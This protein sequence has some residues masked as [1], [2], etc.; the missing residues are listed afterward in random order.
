M[1]ERVKELGCLYGI[2]RIAHRYQGSLDA[3]LREVAAIIRDA[4]QYPEIAS[5][6]IVVDGRVCAA[7]GKGPR[8]DVQACP[9][10]VRGKTRGHVQVAYSEER[11]LLDEGPFLKE[12]RNLIEVVAAQVADIIEHEEVER[13]KGLLL[14]QLRHAD[15]LATIGQLAAGM[16]HELNEPLGGI[17]GFAQLARKSPDLPEQAAGDIERIAAAALHAR[18]VIR[19][20]LH[21]AHQTPPSRAEIDLNRL[22]EDALQLLRSHCEHEAIDIQLSFAPTLPRLLGDGGQLRQVFT[23]LMVNALQA[24][25]HGGTITITTT[26]NDAH[27]ILIVEDTGIGIAEDVMDKL[28]LPFFT[29]KDVGVGT[30]LGLPVA[31]GIVAA[32]G[33]SIHVQSKVGQGSRFEIRL[34]LATFP[35]PLEAS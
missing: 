26:A 1:L 5:V 35:S 18:D 24:M 3:I 2:S 7:S 4:W 27:A 6:R 31:H 23:N 22:I 14:E 25:P 30:G 19:K 12:E 10:V 29:T 17:L 28:F 8:L 15:K 32:H 16:A 20:L 21:F 33:G 11:P 9:I 34:P 13:E